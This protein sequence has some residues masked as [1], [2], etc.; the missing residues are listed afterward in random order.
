MGKSK[1][2]D[3]NRHIREYLPYYV[4][5]PQ[6]PNYAVLISGPWGIGK[7][8]LVKKILKEQFKDDPT[9]YTYVSLYGLTSSEQIDI[10]LLEAH[11]PAWRLVKAAGRVT[12]SLL[13]TFGLDF[14]ADIKPADILKKD[15]ERLYVFDDLERCAMTVDEVLGYINRFIEHH[16]CR[17]VI[18][19][20]ENEIKD[21]DS[22]ASKREKLIG[23]VLQA[24]PV[25][26]E[27]LAD[28]I[29]KLKSKATR[30][31]LT[32]RTTEKLAV[33][34][35]SGFN[36]L[37]ILQQSLWDFERLAKAIDP[38]YFDLKDP[39]TALLQLFLALSFELKSG[40]I[41]KDDLSDRLDKI[42]AGGVTKDEGA[43]K[44]NRLYVASKKYDLYLHADY[45]PE[46]LLID[47]LA[48]GL[49]DQDAVLC[50]HV[51]QPI[52]CAAE[53]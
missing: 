9:G 4:K 2:I 36:N 16:E 33:Y 19:A 27:A 43:K 18:V 45:L 41:E 6:A 17:V 1:A 49:V 12:D 51:R 20:N 42:V 50:L 3:R 53:G 40:K 44:A 32:S 46:P 26:E 15:K 21:Q 34:S 38:S 35:Q 39:I 24:Q 52:L 47:I 7:T 13:K 8:F 37:R 29:S 10:A 22:Y 28:F 11:F 30:E 23:K 48:S 31:L 14:N 5:L 25:T